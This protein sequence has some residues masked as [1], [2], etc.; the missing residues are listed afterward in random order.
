MWG[1]YDKR[2]LEAY[3]EPLEWQYRDEYPFEDALGFAP[4]TDMAAWSEVSDYPSNPLDSNVKS[5]EDFQK[6]VDELRRK[7]EKIERP[8]MW[9]NK[10]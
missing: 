8:N 4:S 1:Y 10:H 2:L 7:Y 6:E 9:E 5:P 3:P